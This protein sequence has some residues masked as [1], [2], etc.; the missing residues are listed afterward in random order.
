MIARHIFFLFG[1]KGHILKYLN[2]KKDKGLARLDGQARSQDFIL[3]G[4]GGSEKKKSE[5]SLYFHFLGSDV[6]DHLFRSEKSIDFRVSLR[7]KE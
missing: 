2:P 4:W 1:W 5:F 6:R 7:R 3:G